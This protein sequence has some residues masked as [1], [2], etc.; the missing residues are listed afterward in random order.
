MKNFDWT[1]PVRPHSILTKKQNRRAK[2]NIE[3]QNFHAGKLC[4]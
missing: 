4:K 3:E 2:N 1:K